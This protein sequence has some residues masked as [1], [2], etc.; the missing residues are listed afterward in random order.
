MCAPNERAIGS[1]VW[2]AAVNDVSWRIESWD[3]DA[4][5]V[6]AAASAI[7]ALAPQAAATNG[8]R[9]AVHRLSGVGISVLSLRF[10]GVR[11]R[12]SGPRHG[13]PASVL[14][15]QATDPP[16]TVTLTVRP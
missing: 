1:A 15:P 10:R 6:G 8:P 14:R 4:D 9:R 3:L 12:R 7:A 13:R 2:G 11:G 16:V 5:A